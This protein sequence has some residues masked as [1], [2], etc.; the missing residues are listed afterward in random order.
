[1]VDC[2][3]SSRFGQK[4][5]LVVGVVHVKAAESTNQARRVAELGSLHRLLQEYE[6]TCVF[7]DVPCV[8][9]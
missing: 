9:S 6:L 4:W 2:F 1:M 3:L 8:I 7:G 5:G